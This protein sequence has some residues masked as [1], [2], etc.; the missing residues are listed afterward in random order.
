M[1]LGSRC[2]A[3][4]VAAVRVFNLAALLAKFRPKK[5]VEKGEQPRH[6]VRSPLKLVDIGYGA[7]ERTLHKVVRTVDVAGEGHRERAQAWDGSEHDVALGRLKRRPFDPL[8]T[9]IDRF[10]TPADAFVC[11]RLVLLPAWHRERD[12]HLL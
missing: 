1:L 8:S 9:H 11:G 2:Q 7:H 5:V 12:S 6:H 4:G 10:L 3:V